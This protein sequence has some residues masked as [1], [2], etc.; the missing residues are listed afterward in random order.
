MLFPSHKEGFKNENLVLENNFTFSLKML[1]SCFRER[2][3]VYTWLTPL[4][5]CILNL[6]IYNE[7]SNSK[8]S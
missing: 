6:L 7:K 1:M 8:D 5:K 2:Y 4:Q 3:L